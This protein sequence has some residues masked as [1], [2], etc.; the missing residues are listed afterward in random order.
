MQYKSPYFKRNL[1]EIGQNKYKSSKIIIMGCHTWFYKKVK[2]PT[3]EEAIEKIRIAHEKEV[4]FLRRMIADRESIDADLLEA[5]PE[6]TPVY[7]QERIPYWE[8]ELENLKDPALS[9]DDVFK[10]YISIGYDIKSYIAGKGFYSSTDELPH[11]L[12]RKYNYPE[13]QLFSLDETLEYIRNNE[14]TTYEWTEEKL[15]E[16][17][18]NH[19]DG[20]ISFG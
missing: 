1:K 12:F 3:R 11:D 18:T 7:A 6:W 4:A 8:S 16:F 10:N 9:D 15:K 17:W 14:C 19:P 2:G 5:Y 20:M 13:D